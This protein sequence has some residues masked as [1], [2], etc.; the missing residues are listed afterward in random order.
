MAVD[1][2][3]SSAAPDPA[4][5]PDL[6]GVPAGMPTAST[7]NVGAPAQQSQPAALPREGIGQG[8]RRA[9]RGTQY[10]VDA[11][12]NVTDS[13]AT[14]P[15]G[16]GEFGSILG[17][18][19]M[20]ALAGMAKSR[21]S[22]VPSSD[23]SGGAGAGV[24]AAVEAAQQRDIRNRGQAETQ[25]ANEQQVQKASREQLES[26]PEPIPRALHRAARIEAR[27]YR[28]NLLVR[29]G[30][31]HA[32]APGRLTR[33]CSSRESATPLSTAIRTRADSIA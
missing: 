11:A 13:R 6:S 12:G 25:F 21:M 29:S 1:I 28:T 33:S 8:I 7:S 23:V 22:G 5:T 31:P 14:A 9:M 15:S 3:P 26:Q 2:Q 27:R 10:V 30:G 19:I 4:A 16:K 17:G 18:I 32:H 24:G 20:G